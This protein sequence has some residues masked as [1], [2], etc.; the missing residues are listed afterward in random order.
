M[1]SR[2]FA[3]ASAKR[4][5]RVEELYGKTTFQ[6]LFSSEPV[7]TF[8]EAKALAG[9]E[10]IRGNELGCVGLLHALQ[11]DEQA[12]RET[13]DSGIRISNDFGHTPGE[14]Q[15][16]FEAQLDIRRARHLLWELVFV[17]QGLKSRYADELVEFLRGRWDL[18]RL[19][20][21][22]DERTILISDPKFVHSLIRKLQQR[23]FQKGGKQHQRRYG[24]PYLTLVAYY[25]N[26][27]QS[28]GPE[29]LYRLRY[30]EVWNPLCSY[31]A[32]KPDDLVS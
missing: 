21:G 11:K 12:L 5:E 29:Q 13:R 6:G 16:V 10:G 1:N 19:A 7:L 9:K 27:F 20:S 30:P 14:T 31:W 8:R 17:L 22:L 32:Q 23:T 4:R 25:A 26:I 2:E 3:E 15:A 24:L 18:V 28:L